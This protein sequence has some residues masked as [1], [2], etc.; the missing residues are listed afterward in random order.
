MAITELLEVQNNRTSLQELLKRVSFKKIKIEFNQKG[1]LLINL[2]PWAIKPLSAKDDS[3]DPK[4]GLRK[5]FGGFKS[6]TYLNKDGISQVVVEWKDA[7]LD[8]YD[9]EALDGFDVKAFI[10]DQVKVYETDP[11]KDSDTTPTSRLISL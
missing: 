8:V 1:H 10:L 4:N 6:F 5:D 2:T 7:P 3:T 11:N 9:D